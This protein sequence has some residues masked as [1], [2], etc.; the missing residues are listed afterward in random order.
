MNNKLAAMFGLDARIAL[1]IFGA[2]SVI[3]GTVLFWGIKDTNVISQKQ[4]SREVLEASYIDA[5]AKLNKH[6]DAEKSKQYIKDYRYARF[7]N[8]NMSEA[9]MDYLKDKPISFVAMKNNMQ[10]GGNIEWTKAKCIN[11]KDCSLWN[12]I[13]CLPEDEQ[14][15]KDLDKEIDE[16]NGA[17]DGNLRWLLNGNSSSKLRIFLKYA[18]IK[19]PAA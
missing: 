12:I 6:K 11:S 10:W 14:F 18:P 1:A 16:S 4:K 3:I 2:L 8:Y 19:K 5:E 17:K 15:I 7:L 13:S 9:S